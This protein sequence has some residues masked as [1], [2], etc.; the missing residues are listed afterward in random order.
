MFARYSRTTKSLRRLFLD[1][2]ADDVAAPGHGRG[3]R[4]RREGRGASTSECSSSTATTRWRSSAGCTSR[5]SSPRSC[6]RRRSSGGGSPP[7]SSSRRGTCATT[8]GPAVGGARPCRPSSTA[9]AA[10]RYL[11]R[12][13]GRRVHDVRAAVRATRALVPGAVPEAA[14]RHRLRLP[15]D[16]AGKDVRHPADAAARRDALEPRDLRDRAVLRAAADAAGAAPARRDAR[17][18]RPDAGRAP[19]GDPGVPQAGRPA[20]ARRRVER[21]L[22]RR[23]ASGR[24]ELAAKLVGDVEPEAAWIGQL[25]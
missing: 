5:A 1:E 19:H 11:R 21:L 10:R 3:A 7:T 12:V 16:D 24:E 13:P 8:T 20:R 23:C 15:P 6:W 25:S 2:F 22:E 17:L 9:H 18:R 14:R 4:M